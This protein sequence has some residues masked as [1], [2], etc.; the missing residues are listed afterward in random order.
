MGQ[1]YVICAQKSG[2]DLHDL[3]M[4]YAAQANT[5]EEAVEI[6]RLLVSDEAEVRWTGDVL[7]CVAARAVGLRPGHARLV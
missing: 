7:S 5:P 3:S 2:G 6:V 4:R 1:A